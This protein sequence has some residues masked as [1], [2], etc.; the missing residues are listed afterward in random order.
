M[1]GTGSFTYL[2]PPGTAGRESLYLDLSTKLDIYVGGSPTIKALLG[3]K[4]MSLYPSPKL[5]W[6]LYP[7]SFVVNWGTNLGERMAAMET[8][9]AG[10]LLNV[11]CCT[12]VFRLT[13]PLNQA[14]FD[15]LRA[16]RDVRAVESSNEL[17]LVRRFTS[18]YVPAPR[19]SKFDYGASSSPFN[20]WDLALSL[21]AQQVLNL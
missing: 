6:D 19:E 10:A 18:A 11:K 21:V 9:A 17:R 16:M 14:D 13:S 4:A 8:M 20:R 12:H 3:L 15:Y 2:Y 7:W 5:A 1:R